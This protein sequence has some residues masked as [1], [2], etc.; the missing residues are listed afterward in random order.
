MNVL[1][2]AVLLSSSCLPLA[3]RSVE[4]DAFSISWAPPLPPQLP[5]LPRSATTLLMPR[6][7]WSPYRLTPTQIT[8]G[9]AD[10]V[11]WI[12]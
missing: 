6:P 10:V 3:L 8:G 1:L 2:A 5:L 4:E 7:L 9:E 12:V 11:G